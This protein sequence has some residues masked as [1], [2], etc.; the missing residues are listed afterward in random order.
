MHYTRE[1]LEDELERESST[2]LYRIMDRAL[3]VQ[4]MKP[5]VD[6]GDYCEGTNCATSVWFV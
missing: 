2:D 1:T 5:E 4:K 3:H 6:Y